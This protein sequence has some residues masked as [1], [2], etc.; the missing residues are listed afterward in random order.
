MK[1]VFFLL[2]ISSIISIAFTNDTKDFSLARVK[3]VSG[4]LVFYNNEPIEKY[5][6][7]FSFENVII[8]YETISTQ[9]VMDESVQNAMKESGLQDGKSFDAIITRS[10]S[11]RDLAIKFASSKKDNSIARIS[12]VNG[13]Y[14]FIECD[15]LSEYDVVSNIKVSPGANRQKTIDKILNK[16][17][18]EEEKESKSF[19]GIL[20]GSTTYNSSIKFKK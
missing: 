14:I 5:E 4:K 7:V 13:K 9:K 3:T 19:D 12:P 15:P 18:K 16:A 20:F 8:N 17:F 6:T 11:K 1:R 2:L 10:N